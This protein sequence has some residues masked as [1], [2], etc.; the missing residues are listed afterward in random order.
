MW[1]K[2]L[3]FGFIRRTGLDTRSHSFKV[4]IIREIDDMYEIEY[5][6]C[7]SNSFEIHNMM[8]LPLLVDKKEVF[9]IYERKL[10]WFQRN[11]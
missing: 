2:I 5:L 8:G 1:N 4:K 9:C 7:M 11:F 3:K 10:N 6:Y